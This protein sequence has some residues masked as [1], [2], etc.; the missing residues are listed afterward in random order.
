MEAKVGT[1][2]RAMAGREKGR[3]MIVVSTENGYVYLADGKERKLGSP[4]K[5][6]IKHISPTKTTAD[7]EKLTDKGLRCF[8]RE[9]SEETKK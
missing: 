7:T 2:V 6:N 5:K 8:L 4:K 1:I 3:F 9:F